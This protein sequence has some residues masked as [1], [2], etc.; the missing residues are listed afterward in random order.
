[1][2]DCIANKDSGKEVWDV[3]KK[4]ERHEPGLRRN[5]F[6][7]FP[8][9]TECHSEALIH[10]LHR[11]QPV[12][13]NCLPRRLVGGRSNETI[14]HIVSGMRGSRAYVDPVE[15]AGKGGMTFGVNALRD[16]GL[17]K[18]SIRCTTLLRRKREHTVVVIPRTRF[19]SIS[20]PRGCRPPT[21]STGSCEK[22]E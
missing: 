1:M 7:T 20:V 15:S 19:V 10:L 14:Q 18:F 2:N 17:R 12:C 3:T 22:M 4:N 11:L 8:I 21:F 9:S 13:P 16:G 6:C 5:P